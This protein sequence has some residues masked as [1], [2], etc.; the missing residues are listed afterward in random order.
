[1]FFDNWHDLLRVVV[2]SALAYGA[3]VLILRVSGKRS[4]SKLNIFDFVVTIALGSTLATVLLSTDVSLAEGALAFA[5]L[6]LLQWIVSFL[7]IRM[8]WFRRMIRA[9]PK[10]LLRN[11]TFLED[12][13]RKE[14]ITRDEIVAVIRKQGQGRI[15]DVA[16]VVLETDGELS[17]ISQSGAGEYSALKSVAG[18]DG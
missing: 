17:V 14:R 11:G 13:M 8:G 3:L 9:E 1:M 2:I 4:L 18:W 7:S 10:L 15:E 16:A 6:A 5:M 12:A